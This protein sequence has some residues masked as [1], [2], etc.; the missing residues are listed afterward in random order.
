MSPR[1]ASPVRTCLGCRRQRPKSEL[2]RLVCRASGVVEPDRTGPGRGAYVCPD[3][4]CVALLPKGGR[5]VR[6]FKRP[7]RALPGLAD[8]VLGAWSEA[9]RREHAEADAVSWSNGARP[10]ALV[11]GAE[12]EAS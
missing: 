2:V 9:I 8:L 4:D 12:P 5:L 1:R 10:V 3:P 11:A 7:A 6:A